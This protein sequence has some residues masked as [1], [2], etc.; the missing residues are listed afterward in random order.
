[1]FLVLQRFVPS[2]FGSNQVS[3]DALP[4]PLKTAYEPKQQIRAAISKEGIP[5]T[6]IFTYGF[7]GFF[8]A[9]LGQLDCLAPP[10]DKVIIFGDGNGKGE[11]EF[12]S[13]FYVPD[14]Q[15]V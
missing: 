10:R 5:F 3:L 12:P 6:I 11:R 15:I 8:L 1:M 14:S 7:A 13:L 2:D 9:N 4:D